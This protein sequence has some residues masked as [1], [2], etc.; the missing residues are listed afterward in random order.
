[1]GHNISLQNGEAYNETKY[2][3]LL[4]VHRNV[5]SLFTR[6]QPGALLVPTF[7]N[8]DFKYYW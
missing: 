2:N 1:V 6:Y 7:G 4:D 5:T 3:M 8:N